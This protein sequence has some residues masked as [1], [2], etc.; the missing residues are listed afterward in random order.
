MEEVGPRADPRHG[1]GGVAA[2]EISQDKIGIKVARHVWHV[3]CSRALARSQVSSKGR[4]WRSG[5]EGASGTEQ[6]WRRGAPCA[7]KRTSTGAR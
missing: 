6:S 4:S 2:V 5:T 7:W 1:L 3:A